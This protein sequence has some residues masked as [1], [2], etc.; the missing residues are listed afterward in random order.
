MLAAE[1]GEDH[2]LLALVATAIEAHGG[3]A[4]HEGKPIDGLFDLPR[5]DIAPA[6]DDQVLAPADHVEGAES[7][8][9]AEVAGADVA[10]SPEELPGSLGVPPVAPRVGRTAHEDLADRSGRRRPVVGEND[11][12]DLGKGPA[13]AHEAAPI[14]S[15]RLAGGAHRDA[16]GGLGEAVGGHHHVAEAESPLELLDGSRAHR[17]GR[18]E[19]DAE[20]GEVEAPV[21]VEVA[22]RDSIGEV[23]GGGEGPATPLDLAEPQAGV[24]EGGRQKKERQAEIEGHHRHQH[25]AH[26]VVNRKPAHEDVGGSDLHPRDHLPDVR[27]ER[28]VPHLDPLRLPGAAGRVLDVGRGFGIGRGNVR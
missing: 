24:A 10:V 1:L 21:A 8:D 7:I 3:R 16:Y 18:V 9:V 28:A 5:S 25:E 20:S 27:Q 14:H 19:S 15:H 23:G 12:L 17:L 13:H 26:V 22:K 4:A 11:D 6:L 2:H